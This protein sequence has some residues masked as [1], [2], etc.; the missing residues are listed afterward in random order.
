MVKHI[1]SAT[2][3]SYISQA[4]YVCIGH[5]AFVCVVNTATK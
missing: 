5:S 2:T 1:I 4:I 3:I